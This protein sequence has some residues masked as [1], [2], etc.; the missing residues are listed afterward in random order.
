M[1]FQRFAM[2]RSKKKLITT[3]VILGIFCSALVISSM[4]VP[5]LAWDRTLITSPILSAPPLDGVKAPIWSSAN[6]SIQVAISAGGL[7]EIELYTLVNASYLYFLIEIR[8]QNHN[9]NEYVK[10]LLSNSTA[11]ATSSFMDAKLIQTNNFNSDSNRS[12][13]L[14]DEHLINGTTYV[15]DSS[16]NFE[17][18][19]NI[20]GT[21]G[22]SYYE[23]KIPFASINSDNINDTSISM[24]NVY[25]VEVQYGINA[26]ATGGQ[27]TSAISP[28]I[29]IQVGVSSTS[30][31][32]EYGTYNI[33]V[34]IISNIMF[35]VAIIA[36]VV[37]LIYSFQARKNVK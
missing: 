5:A 13:Y 29:A 31:N 26:T 35:I 27:Y 32:F 25:S 19:A 28:P 4:S 22:Y 20:T 30:S 14:E 24:G 16:L 8:A 37:I 7:P 6:N 12:Y 17:G 1:T 9:D 2:M 10:L 23:Y 36:F 11:N 34:N 33:D 15:N 3:S 18:V 21:N